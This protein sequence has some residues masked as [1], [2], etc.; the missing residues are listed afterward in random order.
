M[1]SR[2]TNLKYL[3]LQHIRYIKFIVIRVVR[4]IFIFYLIMILIYLSQFFYL[5]HLSCSNFFFTIIINLFLIYLWIMQIEMFLSF[6][7]LKDNK[8][9]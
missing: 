1:S 6:S 8:L 2:I 9:Y 4:W 7:L 3:I 5:S